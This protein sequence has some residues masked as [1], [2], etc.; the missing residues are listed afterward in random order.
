MSPTTPP[1]L[2]FSRVTA[3][4][5]TPERWMMLLHGVFGTGSNLR[6]L[7]R[8]VAERCPGWGFVLPDLRGHGRSLG[9]TPP[10]TLAAAAADLVSLEAELGHP[11]H[12]LGGHSFGGRPA[13]PML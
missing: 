4:G 13:P 9:L 2:A 11:I 12:G 3:D 10:H 6:T 8:R 5:A 1:H 7:A